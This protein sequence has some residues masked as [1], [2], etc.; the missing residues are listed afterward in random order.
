MFEGRVAI[1]TGAGRGLGR[2]HALLLASEGAAVVVNDL[3]AGTDG[4]GSDVGPAGS[5]VGEILAAGG[6]AIANTD[7]VS[8]W[9]GARHLVQ[10]AV[11]EFG[12]LDILINNAGIL[13]DRMLVNLTEDEWDVVM[14]VNAKGHAAPLRHAAAYW[15]EQAKEHGSVTA[16]V[17]NTSS[18][19]G[20]FAN[21]GQA[22]YGA[23]KVAVAGLTMIAAKELGR[24]GVRVNTIA[25]AARTRLTGPGSGEPS[26]PQAFDRMDPAN[27]APWVAYLASERCTMT[28][29]C[30]VVYGG[31]VVLV[32]PW[33]ATAS[34][35]Q[36]GKWTL[37]Q[38]VERGPELDVEFESN[39]PFGY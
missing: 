25:P 9:D 12:R 18:P 5:V 1:V 7:D 17:V 22:N 26:D 33:R 28:G 24:Y 32:E 30:F 15:R 39:N 2:E 4:S 35:E 20:L 14:R 11:D 21:V 10:Q 37:D 19:S 6:S 36:P 13:R 23:A 34:I 38:L 3:G 16:A 31:S 8:D 27:V 29:R